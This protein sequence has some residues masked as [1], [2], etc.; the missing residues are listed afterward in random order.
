MNLST[1]NGWKLSQLLE[2]W[3]YHRDE[4][5]GILCG[6]DEPEPWMVRLAEQDANLAIE[7]ITRKTPAQGMLITEPIEP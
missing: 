1:R 4:R 6:S 5:L 7:K 2:E 3:N